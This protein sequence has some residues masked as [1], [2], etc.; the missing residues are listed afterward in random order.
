MNTSV[1]YKPR[2]GDVM[3]IDGAHIMYLR[4]ETL[5]KAYCGE[6]FYLDKDGK[7]QFVVC[8]EYKQGDKTVKCAGK[9]LARI[10]L[11]HISARQK[12]WRIVGSMFLTDSD[13]ADACDL[14]IREDKTDAEDKVF[15]KTVFDVYEQ[16]KGDS[17]FLETFETRE[18][19]ERYCRKYRVQKWLENNNK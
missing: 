3:V 5:R 12:V 19:A 17:E 15:P 14:E 18:D 16:F 2:K 13:L 4:N 10:T 6:V 1:M 11:F 8:D 9:R 7:E